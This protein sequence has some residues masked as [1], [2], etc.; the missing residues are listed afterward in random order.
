MNVK[1]LIVPLVLI[2]WCAA[3]IHAAEQYRFRVAEGLEALG[4]EELP[5][6]MERLRG[7]P[8]MMLIGTRGTHWR[9]ILNGCPETKRCE[10]RIDD[11]GGGAH[12]TAPDEDPATFPRQLDLGLM[13]LDATRFRLRCLRELCVIRHGAV[14]SEEM[15]SIR[16]LRSEWIELSVERAIDVK[17]ADK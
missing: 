4:D 11:S 15:E 6:G 8:L 7:R 1:M 10:F 17:F 14:G 12:S 16:L 5:P 13:R 2:A 3:P 9:W